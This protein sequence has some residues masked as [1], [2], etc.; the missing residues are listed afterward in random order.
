MNACA[1]GN[2]VT[3]RLMCVPAKY[4]MPGL[5][6]DFG[7]AVNVCHTTWFTPSTN[8]SSAVRLSR[9]GHIE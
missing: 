8:M 4:S 5:P 6:K 1:C 7:E 9:S 2:Q 3:L